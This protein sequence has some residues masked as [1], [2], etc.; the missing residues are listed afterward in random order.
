MEIDF[1]YLNLY[2]LDR[3]HEQAE[4]RLK[5]AL[6]NGDPWETVKQKKDVVT[7][8]AIAVHQRK[9]PIV[10]RSHPSNVQRNEPNF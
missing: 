4:A 7:R 2:D 1:S 8:I 5:A 3:M 10:T 9:Y 6:L